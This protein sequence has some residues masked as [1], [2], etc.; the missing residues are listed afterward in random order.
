M[1]KV[2]VNY[3]YKKNQPSNISLYRGN[4]NLK[5]KINKN[6]KIDFKE[7]KDNLCKSLNE[8]E[9]F[10]NN[11]KDISKYLKLYKLLK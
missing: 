11:I 3:M 8:V 10:L 2:S 9:L 7:K 4:V 6:K 1:Q 5:K